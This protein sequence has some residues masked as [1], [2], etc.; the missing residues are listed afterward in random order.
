MDLTK[1]PSTIPKEVRDWSEK[2]ANNF[3]FSFVSFLSY[4][5]GEIV[6][7]SFGTRRYAKGGVKITEVR[8]RATG[9]HDTI[10]KNLLYGGMTGYIPVFESEDRYSHNSWRCL[11]FSKEDFDKWYGSSAPCKFWC[12]CLNPELLGKVEE[13][14]YCGYSQGDVIEYLN[15]Y[16]ENPTV[17]LYGKLKLPLSSMLMKKAD[18]DKRFR[19]Y[20]YKNVDD[21]RR[22]GAH[23]TAYAYDHGMGIREASE[24]ILETRRAFE[25][26]KALRKQRKKVDPCKVVEWCRENKI[27]FPL[28]NDYIA[29]VIGL[30]LDL[31]DTKNLYPKDFKRMHDLRIAE[32]ESLLAKQD[33][34]K[35]KELYDNFAKAGDK[36]TA[37]EY[38]HNGYS[39][40]APR[41][42]SDLKKE[43]GILGH[44]VGKNGYDKK[45][46]D[47]R[48]VIMFMRQE[49]DPGTP[50]V[51][52][53][54]DLKRA[55]L[56]QAYGKSNS[57]PP[58]EAM[59]VIDEWVEIMKKMM[60]ERKQ[61]CA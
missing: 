8:R 55:E 38:S 45:M 20:L 52:I 51:T 12:V 23:A 50:F 29:A 15:K 14:K 21:V 19:T 3:S 4:R 56:L 61:V 26:I 16:R 25:K 35:R 54:F 44:C 10:V 36:A 43:G 17:E 31:K 33:R 5:Y 37:Y 27:D 46:A 60:K 48:V 41:D 1:I 2:H 6:E 42:V 49:A 18:K 24:K 22:Y 7:R 57:K 53:E 9:K 47:G 13:F 30:K 28:Y 40:I 32:H 11:V 34:V 39:F 59:V 58:F